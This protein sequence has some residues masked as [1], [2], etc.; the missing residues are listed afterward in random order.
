MNLPP[1]LILLIAS[2]AE[3]R[4]IV[5]I[6]GR[7]PP[8]PENR[9]KHHPPE[10]VPCLASINALGRTCR[11]F[12]NIL[13]PTLYGVCAKN[14]KIGRLAM[15]FAVEHQL[16]D[17]VE[18]LVA[19]GV[20]LDFEVVCKTDIYGLLHVAAALG[21]L[22]MVQ[23]LL[24]V[25]GHGQREDM[26]V[27]AY[28]R[29]GSS[30]TSPL[31]LAAGG[32]RLDVV[33]VLAALPLPLAPIPNR[34][35][36]FQYT[37]ENYDAM[38]PPTDGFET[39]E[40]YIGRALCAAAGSSEAPLE[41]IEFLAALEGADLNHH[42]APLIQ[43]TRSG[44]QSCIQLLLKLGADPNIHGEHNV[45]T[46]HIAAYILA[47]GEIVKTLLDGGADIDDKDGAGRTPLH[48]ALKRQT[49]VH[50]LDAE[51]TRIT[52]LLLERGADVTALDSQGRTPLHHACV[53]GQPK[54]V[55]NLVEMLL[56]FGA[57]STVEVVD[58]HVPSSTPIDMAMRKINVDAIIAMQPHVQDLEFQS[59]VAVWL[60]EHD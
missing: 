14:K 36:R 22:S 10:R 53:A 33:R 56:Q 52:R 17:A 11:S 21:H 5:D 26:L 50:P 60:Q 9:R 57:G 28:R 4:S 7:F 45:S 13:N 39:R 25:Y 48:L 19:V 16:E 34:V 31:D 2:F 8:R 51:V 43:A 29:L 58:R 15:L 49:S 23:K 24:D 54:H 18:K 41:V 27:W 59:R 1:E 37:L 20:S 44:Q 35:R 30:N 3:H 55:W 46:L 42:D 6:H 32:N 40:T 12:Y 38:L 47:S